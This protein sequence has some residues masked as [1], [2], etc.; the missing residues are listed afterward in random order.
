[1][2]STPSNSR[3]F[4]S[5]TRRSD[6]RNGCGAPNLYRL[7]LRFESQAEISDTYETNIGI[8]KIEYAVPDSEFLTV[9][10]NGMRA[11]V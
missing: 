4:R 8:R 2:P 11:R 6:G 3:R 9:S 7:R 1:L 10:V 5:I